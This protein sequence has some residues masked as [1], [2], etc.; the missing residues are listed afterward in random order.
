MIFVSDFG[1]SDIIMIDLPY[2]NHSVFMTNTRPFDLEFD[3]VEQRLYWVD[4]DDDIVY[5]VGMEPGAT[6][7]SASTVKSNGIVL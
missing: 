1:S 6:R 4:V 3:N 2:L 7:E 5:R